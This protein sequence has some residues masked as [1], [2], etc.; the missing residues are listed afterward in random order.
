MAEPL[1]L[2]DYQEKA[3]AYL[4]SKGG[5][6]LADDM[7]LGKTLVGVELIRRLR[8]RRVLI[9]AP[10]STHVSWERTLKR[11]FPSLAN[12]GLLHRV[13]TLTKDPKGWVRMQHD[14]MGVFI[15]GWEAMR[16]AGIA[17]N[18][19]PELNVPGTP[20]VKTPR[21]KNTSSGTDEFDIRNVWKSFSSF[22]LVIA[23]EV[24]QIQDKGSK[25]SLVLKSIK[26]VCRLGISATPSG[27]HPKGIWSVLNWLWKERYGG[28]WKWAAENLVIEPQIIAGRT[29]R[30]LGPEIYPGSTW[31]GIPAAVRRKAEDVLGELPPVVTHYVHV[32]MTPKQEKVYR[33]F[34]RRALATLE[35]TP[36]LTP[37]PVEQRIR[38]RGAALGEMR[39]EFHPDPQPHDPDKVRVE[40]FFLN[41]SKN[42]KITKA[43]EIITE[44]KERLGSTEPVL[45]LTHSSKF[46]ELANERFSELWNSALWTGA[47]SSKNREGILEKFGTSSGPSVL[48][49]SIAAVGQGTDGLQR[50]CANEIWLSQADSMMLNTQ[51][52]G[53]L[54]RQGQA[55]VVNR[56]YVHTEG[57]IDHKVYESNGEKAATMRDFYN[58]EQPGG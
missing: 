56:Y 9:V 48:V 7:G 18:K 44:I 31:N 27:G 3:V 47:V 25:N 43:V 26:A 10:I 2:R 19:L 57:T 8:A 33:D 5:G 4:A 11:Q 21:S 49:C 32:G 28:F 42:I 20:Q 51:A 40:T 23:D 45:V 16:G 39:A 52:T 22:N 1:V 55:R 46:A 24:H 6:L 13:G 54:H 58:D 53:R 36:V 50:V 41:S 17:K 14:D 34:E 37:L 12:N 30:K 29:V 15:I 38:L 35:G